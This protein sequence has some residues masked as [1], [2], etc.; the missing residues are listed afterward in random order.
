VKTLKIE[1]LQSLLEAHEMLV[2]AR[3]SERSGQQAVQAQFTKKD[4]Y[5]KYS[6]KKGKGKFR[7]GNWG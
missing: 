6:K 5:D 3:G 7:K 2:I 1:K 4:G